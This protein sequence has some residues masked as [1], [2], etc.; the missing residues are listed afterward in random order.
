MLE[1]IKKDI[2]S[3][4]CILFEQ[5]FQKYI[6]KIQDISIENE[7]KFMLKN[8]FLNSVSINRL[9]NDIQSRGGLDW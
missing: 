6:I 4:P 5:Y 9:L 1:T 7:I 2:Q 8:N 3:L